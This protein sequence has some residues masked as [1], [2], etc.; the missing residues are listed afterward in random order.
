MAELRRTA[1]VVALHLLRNRALADL[2]R[3][4]S[5]E[6]LRTLLGGGP[7]DPAA[8]TWLP[9]GPWR[10]VALGPTGPAS[11][12]VGVEGDLDVWESRFR[13]RGWRQPLLT[14]LGDLPYAVVTTTAEP[15]RPAAAGTWPWLAALA[16]EAEE[17][18]PSSPSGW[19]AAG[20]VVGAPVELAASARS[21]AQVA[22]LRRDDPAL[23]PASTAEDRWATL[24]VNRAVSAITGPGA[25]QAALAGPVT[26]L[27]D[28]DRRRHTAYL[29]SLA[30]WLDHPGEPTAAAKS[31]G[32]HVNTLRHR[33]VRM[34]E[35]APLRLDDPTERLAL[36]LQLAAVGV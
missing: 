5:A 14:E 33:M 21:A 4:L 6:R 12:S 24:T 32:V 13:R 30:A 26:A 7:V 31:L 22:G 18:D 29:P 11:A 8:A 25:W 20:V 2:T 36:R 16:A 3:R 27:A 9:P 28:H 10:A 1:S 23:G 35:V 17:S 19:V 15:G 34:S